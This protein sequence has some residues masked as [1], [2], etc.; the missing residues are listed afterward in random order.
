M[1]AEIQEMCRAFAYV[2]RQYMQKLGNNYRETISPYYEYLVNYCKE[3]G[4]SPIDAL[5]IIKKYDLIAGNIVNSETYDYFGCAVAE[6]MG[7]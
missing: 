7:L 3:S 5:I 2:R 4:N 1:E 6:I